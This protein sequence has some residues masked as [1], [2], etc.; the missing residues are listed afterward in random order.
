MFGILIPTSVMFVIALWAGLRGIQN[1]IGETFRGLHKVRLASFFGGATENVLLA[2][3]LLVAWLLQANFGLSDAVFWAA[4]ASGLGAFIAFLVLYKQFKFATSDIGFP[5]GRF[6]APAFPMMI[7]TVMTFALNQADIWVLG[8]YMSEDKV[9]IYGAAKRLVVTMVLPL[10]IVNAVIAPIISELNVSD[11][12]VRLEHLLRRTASL[13]SFPVIVL[14]FIFIFGADSIMGAAFGGGY[15]SGSTVLVILS[16]GYTVNVCTGSCARVLQM[17]GYQFTHMVVTIIF[18]LIAIMGSVLVVGHYELEG[19][20][21][22]VAASIAVQNMA[23]LFIV[24]RRYG[25][26]THVGHL[27]DAMQTLK[28]LVLRNF[29]TA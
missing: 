15:A 4:I 19:V 18:G 13:S 5:V 10:T 24:R 20:A 6:L 11:N 23:M 7:T 21:A 2:I 26:W 1:L 28:R 8:A 14:L 9:A 12:K 27:R 3:F 17:T 25:I 29:K 22:V 16:L